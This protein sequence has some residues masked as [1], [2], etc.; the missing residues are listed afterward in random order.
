MLKELSKA[1]MLVIKGGDEKVDDDATDYVGG[2]SV[3]SGGYVS[4]EE[5]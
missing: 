4:A 3:S 1:E 5:E 2:G